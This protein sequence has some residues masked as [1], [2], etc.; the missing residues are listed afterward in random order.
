V[1]VSSSL[2]AEYAVSMMPLMMAAAATTVSKT[3]AFL[4]S[5]LVTSFLSS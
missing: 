2:V 3:K 5:M 1:L 4:L